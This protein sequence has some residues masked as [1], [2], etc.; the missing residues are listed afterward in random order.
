MRVIKDD[1]KEDRKVT[2]CK[3]VTRSRDY[4]GTF[5][6]VLVLSQNCDRDSPS[7][8]LLSPHNSSRRNE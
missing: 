5:P 3:D 6:D 2:R 4:E 1:N 8:I 7:I